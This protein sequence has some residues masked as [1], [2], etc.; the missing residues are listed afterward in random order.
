MRRD[1]LVKELK[2]YLPEQEV[3]EL[4][5]IIMWKLKEDR[6][7]YGALGFVMGFLIA[8]VILS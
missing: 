8:L 6:R 3:R 4:S 1:W 5:E 2:E 7:V